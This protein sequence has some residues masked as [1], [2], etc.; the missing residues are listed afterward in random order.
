MDKNRKTSVIILSIFSL[1]I[2]TMWF[3]NINNS[4]KKPFAVISGE[5]KTEKSS[6]QNN[7]FGGQCFDDEFLSP[8]NLELKYM[9][10][11]GDGIS[12]WDELFVYGTS[13]Y[14]EDTS[15]DGISDY[16]AIFVYNIDP[17]CPIGQDCS[18]SL[19]QDSFTFQAGSS[20]E[21]SFD[22]VLN[23]MSSF[24]VSDSIEEDEK[25]VTAPDDILK[26]LEEEGINASYLRELLILSGFDKEDLQN[27]SD[28]ELMSAYKEAFLQESGL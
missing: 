3:I 7:C 19:K 18:S 11:D 9:D 27:I 2:I 26:S 13:P 16:D 12:D 20:F 24:D 15:G 1:F 23:L 25:E 22:S 10:T 8:E 4:L 5:N 14:L 6:T 21:Q 28:E 17:L